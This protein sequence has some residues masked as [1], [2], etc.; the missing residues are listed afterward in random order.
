MK[1]S[2]EDRITGR[3]HELKGKVKEEIGKA[4]KDPDLEVSGKAEKQAGKVQPWI[5]HA[6]KAVGE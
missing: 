4:T 6:E 2:T 5:G 1:P 3:L